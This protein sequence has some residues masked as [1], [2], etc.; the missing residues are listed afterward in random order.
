MSRVVALGETSRVEGYALAGVTVLATDRDGVDRAWQRV[1]DDTG[2]LVLTPTAAADLEARLASR[3]GL[4]W[5]VIP[6]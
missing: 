2:L 6:T 5:T 3:P 1:P 4:L